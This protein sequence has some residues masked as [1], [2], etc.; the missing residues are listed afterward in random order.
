M[1]NRSVESPK[2]LRFGNVEGRTILPSGEIVPLDSSKVFH[3]RAFELGKRY[4]VLKTTFAFSSVQ[5]GAILEYQTER[6]RQIGSI[7]RR[8]FLIPRIWQHS[9]PRSA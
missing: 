4:A 3:G 9:S 1:G 7:H 2:W 5:P 6:R 8:G